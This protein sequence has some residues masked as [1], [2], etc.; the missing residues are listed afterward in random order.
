MKEKGYLEVSEEGD[1]RN[2]RLVYRATAKGRKS[3]LNAKGKVRELFSELLETEL[4]KDS[5]RPSRRL[6]QLARQLRSEAE[7]SR[8]GRLRGKLEAAVHVLEGLASTLE[9]VD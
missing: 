3:L 1:G 9:E 7:H 6:E 2:A 5:E 4:E 8:E